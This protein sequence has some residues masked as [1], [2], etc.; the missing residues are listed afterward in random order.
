MSFAQQKP[1]G[2]TIYEH[3]P[4]SNDTVLMV[5][6]IEAQ[7]FQDEK[8]RKSLK[9]LLILFWLYQL[10][11]FQKLGTKSTNFR[12]RHL[13]SQGSV[14]EE[15][16]DGDKTVI[17]SIL[18]LK[19]KKSQEF[20]HFLLFS[21]RL[22]DIASKKKHNA[23]FAGTLSLKKENDALYWSLDARNQADN[24]GFLTLQLWWRI[25][26]N[27]KLQLLRPFNILRRELSRQQEFSSCLR[28]YLGHKTRRFIAGW[29][30]NK[31]I[32]FR[33]HVY[34]FWERMTEKNWNCCQFWSTS[35]RLL[36]TEIDRDNLNLFFRN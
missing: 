3:C 28:K 31:T 6:L 21:N 12:W 27:L 35:F 14:D 33:K 17:L 23:L 4:F 2:K 36:A 24:F 7:W 15:L 1:I 10:L 26:S 9:S 29:K 8:L 30:K 32:S 25:K 13:C 5:D 18:F 19:I 16:I 11:S 34:N 20:W 22:E